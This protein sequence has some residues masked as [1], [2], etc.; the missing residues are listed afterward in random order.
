VFNDPSNTYVFKCINE[1]I[2]RRTD[3]AIKRR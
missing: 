1:R 2:N 3:S